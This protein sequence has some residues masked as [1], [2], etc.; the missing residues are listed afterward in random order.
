MAANPDDWNVIVVGAWNPAILTPDGIARRL[1]ELNREAPVEVQVAIDQQAPIRVVHGG[2]M[3]IPSRNNLVV[4]PATSGTD[5]LRRAATIL[6]RA[7]RKLPETPMT[8]AGVNIRFRLDPVPD[9]L[10]QI[11]ESEVDARL[12]DLG[13]AIRHRGLKRRLTWNEGVVNCQW[14]HDDEGSRVGYNFHLASSEPEALA[15]WVERCEEMV[16]EASR[17]T[18]ECLHVEIEEGENAVH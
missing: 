3:V 7:V 10:I 11:V 1:F 17:L 13:F 4:Q 8:A 2:L 16:R 18:R 5:G 6:A 12:A 9:E 14:L 15:R